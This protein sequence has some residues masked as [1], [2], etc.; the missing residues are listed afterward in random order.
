MAS[1]GLQQKVQ[2]ETRQFAR[3]S[4]M[5]LSPSTTP[6]SDDSQSVTNDGTATSLPPI[7]LHPTA[8]AHNF[9]ASAL[10]APYLPVPIPP[11][12]HHAYT[13]PPVGQA[14]ELPPKVLTKHNSYPL[15]NTHQYQSP[16]TSQG[17][18]HQ[19]AVEHGRPSSDSQLK[20]SHPALLRIHGANRAYPYPTPPLGRWPSVSGPDP[21][22]V[23]IMAPYKTSQSSTMVSTAAPV[24]VQPSVEQSQ[25]P[26]TCKDHQH[27]Y[28]CESHR[29]PMAAEA[30][31][32]PQPRLQASPFRHHPPA[33]DHT[34]DP[35]GH[36]SAYA[37]LP[38]QP[39]SD[40]QVY[41]SAKMEPTGDP[42]NETLTWQMQGQPQ[43]CY[44]HH[45]HHHHHHIE[46]EQQQLANSVPADSEPLPVSSNAA[47]EQFAAPVTSPYDTQRFPP[48]AMNF[49]PYAH[50]NFTHPHDH[51]AH[52]PQNGFGTLSGGPHIQPQYQSHQYIHNPVA[53][54]TPQLASSHPLHVPRNAGNV[55]DGHTAAY[56]PM[57]TYMATPP[58]SQGPHSD[59]FGSSYRQG[60]PMSHLDRL[61]S[62]PMHLSPSPASTPDGSQAYPPPA[63]DDVRKPVK[64]S[65][66]KRY[67]C[68]EC[69]K[70]FTRPS[71]LRT[72]LNSHTGEKPFLC[73]C[74]RSFSVLSNLRRHERG[75]CCANKE[76]VAPR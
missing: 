1:S 60:P 15:P 47:H 40:A 56:M 36:L 17:H 42:V 28:D 2:E 37:H 7:L 54:A 66:H 11:V 70:R 4:E 57:M 32:A 9:A 67:V 68:P 6:P 65:P 59:D 12:P 50:P 64:S 26:C 5:S 41:M 29:A 72:H 21:H 58:S 30:H 55:P 71:S 53:S 34:A 43:H 19:V 49:S 18:S 76:S 44:H 16:A 48:H 75:G 33:S 61:M 20:G 8:Y 13:F 14:S 74:G 63:S 39:D 24:T 31:L 73:V 51:Y 62:G 69:A 25:G 3:P 46:Q 23:S 52:P 22:A 38:A 35:V 27:R 10:P 45:H